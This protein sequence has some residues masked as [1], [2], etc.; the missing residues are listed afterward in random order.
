MR[1]E[2]VFLLKVIGWNE[3]TVL[4]IH[5]DTGAAIAHRHLALGFDD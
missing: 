4:E 3:K 1:L 2:Y 5:E